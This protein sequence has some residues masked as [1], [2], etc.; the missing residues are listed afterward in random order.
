MFQ[1]SA[2][3]KDT[4]WQHRREGK[5]YKRRVWCRDHLQGQK[6]WSGC[7]ALHLSQKTEAARKCAFSWQENKSHPPIPEMGSE[8]ISIEDLACTSTSPASR[9]SYRVSC[10]QKAVLW[11]GLQ[12]RLKAKLFGFVSQ[13]FTLLDTSAFLCLN[14]LIHQWK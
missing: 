8:P 3:L 13:C 6:T 9:L 10:P 2:S 7:L 5:G 12:N 1:T 4:H 11:C 14:F